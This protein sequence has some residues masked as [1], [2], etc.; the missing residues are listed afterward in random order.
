[1]TVPAKM[2]DDT[3]KCNDSHRKDAKDHRDDDYDE[4]SVKI[5]VTMSLTK[6]KTTTKLMVMMLETANIKIYLL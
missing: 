5:T 1:M 6:I 4:E 2:Q 3:S